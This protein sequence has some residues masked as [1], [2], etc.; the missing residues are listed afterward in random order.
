[1][2]TKEEKAMWITALRTGQ[3]PDGREFVQ[4]QGMLVQ[5]RQG[6][7]E[8]C[9]LGVACELFIPETFGG[10]EESCWLMGYGGETESLPR[11]LAERMGLSIMGDYN[12]PALGVDVPLDGGYCSLAG[13]NDLDI[14]FEEI[15]DFLEKHLK[16]ED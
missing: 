4:G 14:S 11:F 9:C 12:S 16:T 15:A 6:V 5:R 10:N 8:Y 13:M 7:M 1:M 3:F 2:L